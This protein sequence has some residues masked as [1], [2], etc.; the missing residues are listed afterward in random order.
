MAETVATMSEELRTMGHR[1][2]AE[3][4]EEMEKTGTI[5]PVFIV[6]E[7]DGQFM[8]FEMRDEAGKLMNIGQ[9]KSAIFGWLRAYVQQKEAL[10]CILVGE[11]WHAHSTEKAHALP[12]DELL[13]MVRKSGVPELVKQGWMTSREVI[14]INV[15]SPEVMMTLTLP[16]ERNDRLRL[17]TFGTLETAESGTIMPVFDFT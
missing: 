6:Q 7:K 14:N 4:R 1:A 10:G 15:Q 9:A 2:L 5:T 13:E 8:R 12:K 11:A 16:F 17:V 3:A